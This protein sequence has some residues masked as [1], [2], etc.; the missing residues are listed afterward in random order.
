MSDS[1]DPTD[2]ATAPASPAAIDYARDDFDDAAVNTL[3]GAVMGTPSYMAPEQARGKVSELDQRADVYA[4]GAILYEIL[5]LQRAV[6]GKTL[7]ALLMKVSMGDLTPLS[8]TADPATRPHC[9]NGRI[10]DSLAAVAM[11]ALA[12]KPDDRYATVQELQTEIEAYHGGFATTAEEAGLFRQL[13]LLIKRHKAEFSLAAAAMVIIASLVA[14]FVVKVNT[15]KNAALVARNEAVT[16][17]AEEA[18]Q[19]KA[20]E[21]ARAAEAERSEELEY[22]NYVNLIA[23]ADARIQSGAFDKAEELLWQTPKHLRHWEWGYLLK[24]CQ[25]DLLTLRGH[26]DRVSTMA[27]SPD[28]RLLAT[29]GGDCTAKIWDV[30]NGQKLLEISVSAQVLCLAFSPGGELL[31]TGLSNGNLGVAVWS[32]ETGKKLLRLTPETGKTVLSGVLSVAFFPDGKRLATTETNGTIRVWDLETKRELLILKSPQVVWKVSVAPDGRRMASAG[33]DRKVHMWDANSGKE[34]WSVGY[35]STMCYVV[36]SPDGGRLATY[37]RE[38]VEIRSA[39]TGKLEQTLKGHTTRVTRA[40]F[41]GDGHCLITGDLNGIVKIWDLRLGVETATL[42]GHEASISSVAFSL[43]GRLAASSSGDGTVRLWRADDKRQEGVSR[44]WQYTSLA[45]LSPDG[46]RLVG[47]GGNIAKI[48]ETATG[49]QLAELRGHT[50]GIWSVAFAPDG[51]HVLTG[52]WDGTARIWDARNGVEQLTLRG[53]EGKVFAAAWSPNGKCILTTGEDGSARIWDAQTGKELTVFLPTN[54]SASNAGAFSPD[55]NLVATAQGRTTRLWDVVTGAEKRKFSGHRASVFAVVF[56]LD[57]TRLATGGDDKIV[58]THDVSSGRELLTLKGSSGRVTSL[59]F[60]RDGRRLLSAGYDRTVRVWDAMIGRELL[61]LQRHRGT[62][63]SVT[64]FPDG[65]RLMT[66]GGGG[67]G[68]KFWDAYDW[69][70][71]REQ[72]EQQ[73]LK[74]YREFM[75]QPVSGD[76]K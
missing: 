49:E 41:S 71:T 63:R 31:A 36:F 15:E 55:G 32:V 45:A 33:D 74:R 57:G 4:L 8:T 20:A 50:E 46:G 40:A 16:A 27:F 28:G 53:H 19:R 10:P 43:G 42:I 29:G 23:V 70:L 37:R 68:V 17:Q 9:P 14:G 62:I 58:T 39:D 66:A 34:L 1:S 75:A 35:P 69:T 25:P 30:R 11:K 48:W 65:R 52:S 54:T 72:L 44:T 73:K 56:S 26:G 59:T 38:D 6:V 76:A 22:E 61:V 60:C 7:T 12:L 5:S 2:G 64:F 13:G 21:T 3:D 47:C 51:L 24:C 18:R 67:D